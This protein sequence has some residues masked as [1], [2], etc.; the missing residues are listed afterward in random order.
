MTQ[1][2]KGPST[3]CTAK[4]DNLP[5]DRVYT[6]SAEIQCNGKGSDV[7]IT[8]GTSDTIQTVVQPPASCV[9][10]CNDYHR[11]LSNV[12]ITS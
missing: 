1:V 5:H 8:A 6:L 4:F 10:S 11:L 2:C 12:D 3:T 9:D 7:Q